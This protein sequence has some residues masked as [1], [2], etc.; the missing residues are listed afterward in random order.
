VKGEIARIGEGSD[1]FEGI[2]C[3]PA[4]DSNRSWGCRDVRSARCLAVRQ[5]PWSIPRAGLV[6]RFAPNAAP[7]ATEEPVAREPRDRHRDSDNSAMTPEPLSRTDGSTDEALL[8]DR[9][10]Q[11]AAA[12]PYRAERE[13]AWARDFSLCYWGIALYGQGHPFAFNAVWPV[14]LLCVVYAL[15]LHWRLRDR[16]AIRITAW[17][18][19]IGDPVVMFM[20][21]MVTGGVNSIFV[22][23]F[24]FSVFAT[25]FRYGVIETLAVFVFN[26]FLLVAL[27]FLRNHPVVGLQTLTLHL[28]YI[29]VACALGAMVAGWARGNLAIA[30]TQSAALRTE[31]DRSQAL[32]QRLIHAQEQ[33]RKRAADDLHDRMGARLFSM[34][35]NLDQVIRSNADN[36]ALQRQL[37]DLRVEA[38]A[39]SADVRALMNDMRPTVLDDLG[40]HEALRDYVGNLAGRVPFA[41]NLDLDPKLRKWHSPQDAM[42]FRLVQEAILNVRK[43]ADARRV[44]IALQPAGGDVVLSIE[45]DGCGFDPESVPTGHYG[46]LTMRERAELAG[47]RLRIRSELLRGT[48][49]EV[50]LP[51]AKQGWLS[52][53]HS[54][55]PH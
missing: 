1:P 4:D 38:D 37:R 54:N 16:S 35:Q 9:A 42:L 49:I 44:V 45:D 27:Y 10:Y 41:L 50:H 32:L 24:Y 21:C 12:H 39:C 7:A 43:H 47:G 33:E 28:A 52:E 55:L 30:L 13:L 14:Y 5:V 18:G 36:W 40:L 48:R 53:K 3:P 31:R 46:L 6:E 8:A 11:Q 25:A 29:T 22:P 19:T 51:L 15:V 23:F 17:F 34:Q 2:G 26:A 20:M